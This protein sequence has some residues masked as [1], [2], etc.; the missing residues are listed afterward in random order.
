MDNNIM[1]AIVLLGEMSDEEIQAFGKAYY[2]KYGLMEM[3]DTIWKASSSLQR[4]RDIG[5]GLHS[6]SN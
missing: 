2:E 1:A 5:V 6:A 3:S 4:I